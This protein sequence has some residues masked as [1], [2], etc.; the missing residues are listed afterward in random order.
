MAFKAKHL[1]YAPLLMAVFVG[2][3]CLP[4]VHSRLD[5]EKEPHFLEGKSR[6]NALDY[7]GAIEAYEKAVE[8]NPQSG[9][10]HL[11]LGL[12]YEQNEQD[13]AAAIYHFQRF[14]VLR[15]K[16]EFE[17]RVNQQILAC[18]QELAKAVSLPAISQKLQNDYE[19]MTVTNKQLLVEL[20]EARAY[21]AQL[22]NQLL[23][24]QSAVKSAA[25]PSSQ[26]LLPSGG[27]SVMGMK[28]TQPSSSGLTHT[29]KSGETP[30]VIARKYGIKV[31]ALMAANPRLDARRMQV[32]KSLNIPSS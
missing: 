19:K 24:A 28:V 5:E 30:T 26:I 22:T 4:T 13:Y 3:G 6:F 11:E 15:P 2:A 31:E 1:I 12:L 7:Q 21:I 20:A 29:V 16:S 32:G 25:Q 10:A 23:R 18:K 9:A 8:V 17:S 27:S 14:L